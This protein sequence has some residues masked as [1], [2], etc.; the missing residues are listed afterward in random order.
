MC[1][2]RL[3]VLL[4][5]CGITANVQA[6]GAATPIDIPGLIILDASVSADHVNN[7][8][9]GTTG[10]PP[11]KPGTRVYK[12]Q[13]TQPFIA[14]RSYY[15]PTDSNKAG[16]AG[17]WIS[18]IAETRG[19]SRAQLL[20]RL[21][22]PVYT[23]GTRNNAFAL[24]LVP[25]G[26]SFWS[27]PA[28]PITQSVADPKGTY[29]GAG[30]GI[31]Y[32]VGRNAGDVSGFQV[33]IK[34][35]VLAAPMGE[36]YLLAYSPRLT[37]NASAVG[38]YLDGLTVNAYTD[39][40][41]VLT[42]LD[43]INLS[44]PA[45]DP[46]LQQAVA[47]LGAERHSALGLVGLHQSRSF[48]DQLTAGESDSSVRAS[49]VA[50]VDNDQHRGWIHVQSA[51]GSQSLDAERTGF[52]LDTSMV[53]AGVEVARRSNWV[54]GAGAGVFS[55]RIDW[56]ESAAGSG[57]LG[58]GYVGAYGVYRADP[59]VTTG[60]VLIGYSNIETSRNIAIPD[61]GLWPGYSFA[62]NRTAQG[63][64]HALSTG[65]RLDLSRIVP[66]VNTRFVPFA[67]IEYQ[68][69]HQDSFTETGA[70][71]INLAVQ[72]NTLDELRLRLGFSLE[73]SLGT[74]A[75]LHWSLD[76]RVLTSPRLSAG[77]GKLTAGF[78][79]QSGTFSSEGWSSP[80]ELTRA[81]IGLLGRS[82]STE[83]SLNYYNERGSG[84]EANGVMAHV[85][86]RF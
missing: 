63:S 36:T 48:L 2:R 83:V 35:Y 32:Y 10:N 23:D 81:G 7:I 24:V 66:I 50:P 12:V 26:T 27:G 69:F 51:R 1:L 58:T 77:S 86:W 9:V 75:N 29:W 39:L 22:L 5:C 68:R 84:F 60:Q 33:P 21:A 25:A 54:L 78:A 8:T 57:K 38:R 46:K 44:T 62:I 76:G 61:A 71:D 14:I 31:Q 85:S 16:Q 70:G 56:L 15:L 11:F 13:T 52:E 49:G 72:S 42:S 74:A 20:D 18:P 73:A 64:R 30:G 79:G 55:S 34:N 41:K 4:F 3:A 28:G 45:G 80:A 6:T 47:N 37:G 53:M 59:W 17:G 67:G 43:L 19:L 65:A 40:D 82:S